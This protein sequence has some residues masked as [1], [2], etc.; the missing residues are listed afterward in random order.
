MSDALE[1]E[2]ER[3]EKM[4]KRGEITDA[5]MR[6]EIKYLQKEARMYEEDN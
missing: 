3:I 4:H 6:A 5:E 1:K 2:I